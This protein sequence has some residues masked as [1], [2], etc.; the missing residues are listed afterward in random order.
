MVE[1][2]IDSIT[3]SDTFSHR[4]AVCLCTMQPML[5]GWMLSGSWLWNVA[6]LWMPGIQ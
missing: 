3:L 2:K 4:L 5:E 6:V 1:E